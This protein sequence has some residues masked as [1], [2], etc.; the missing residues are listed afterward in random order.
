M[1]LPGGGKGNPGDV[2]EIRADL[3]VS[4]LSEHSGRFSESKVQEVIDWYLDEGGDE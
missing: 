4:A 2:A 3:I 1:P